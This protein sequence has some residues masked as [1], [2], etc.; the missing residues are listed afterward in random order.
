[1]VSETYLVAK[2]LDKQLLY[3]EKKERERK[4]MAL[5]FGCARFLDCTEGGV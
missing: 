5:F 2:E 1:M 3:G 4:R